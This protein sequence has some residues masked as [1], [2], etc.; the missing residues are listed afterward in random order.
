MNLILTRM[1]IGSEGAFGVLESEAGTRVCYTLEHA[2]AMDGWRPKVPV[3]TYACV[4]GM[5]QLS[6]HLEPFET[7]EITGVPGH[8]GILFHCGNVEGDSSGCVLLG[9]LEKGVAL[10]NSRK[11]F[12]EFMAIQSGLDSF[13]LVVA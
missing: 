12:S 4:R 2:Y 9:D 5:H 10:I 3:G 8:T 1:N 7:F 6:G 11:A 13:T